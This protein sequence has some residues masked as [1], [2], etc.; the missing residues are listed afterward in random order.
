MPVTTEPLD[1]MIDRL[2]P[3]AL[4]VEQL[5]QLVTG[6]VLAG[7]EFV[8]IKNERT[9]KRPLQYMLMKPNGRWLTQAQNSDWMYVGSKYAV[10]REYLEQEGLQS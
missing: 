4:T 5:E 6:L 7:C 9:T 3:K 2:M 8:L 10:A 1:Q